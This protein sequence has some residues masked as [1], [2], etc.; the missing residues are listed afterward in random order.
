MGWVL[1]PRERLHPVHTESRCRLRSIPG[2]LQESW[3]VD[4][5]PQVRHAPRRQRDGCWGLWGGRFGARVGGVAGVVGDRCVRWP[6][7]EAEGR[8]ACRCEGLP[9]GLVRR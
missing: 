6:E 3:A 8:T 1:A 2:G 4:G 9:A 7:T 5:L